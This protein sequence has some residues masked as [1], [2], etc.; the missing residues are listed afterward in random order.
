MKHILEHEAS[1]QLTLINCNKTQQDILLHK[2]LDA[3]QQAHGQRLHIFH[4]LSRV[5]EWPLHGHLSSDMLQ[6]QIFD[7]TNTLAQ[8]DLF[9][10][11]GPDAFNQHVTALLK[12][13][14]C[15]KKSIFL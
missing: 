5:K 12:D 9:I 4:I 14:S 6:M 10:T 11:C 8:Q 15:D 3:L 1:T 7:T 13:L 2:E